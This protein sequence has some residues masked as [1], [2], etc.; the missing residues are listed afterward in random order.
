VRKLTDIL[1][2]KEKEKKKEIKFVETDPQQPFPNDTVKYLEKEIG[3]L[4]RD[5]TIDWKNPAELVNQ[6]FMNLE[7]PIPKAYLKERWKQYTTLLGSAI[8]NLADAR[9]FG[10]DWC[11]S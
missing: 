10:G 5:L 9:G 4:A 7:V 3:K 6:A 2:E 11:G 1:L 8:K